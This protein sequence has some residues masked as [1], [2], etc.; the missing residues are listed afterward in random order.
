MFYKCQHGGRNCDDQLTRKGRSGNVRPQMRLT[1]FPW[2]VLLCTTPALHAQPTGATPLTRQ[3]SLNECIRMA[4]EHNLDIKIGR[5]GPRIDQLEYEASYGYYDP[6]FSGRAQQTF[7]S[8]PGRLDPAVG[9][10]PGSET[11]REDFNLSLEGLLPTGARYE[12]SGHLQRLSGERFDAETTNFVN[13]PFQYT[14]DVAIS[15]QQPL[16]KNFWIDEGRLNIQ[17]RKKDIKRSEL[18]LQFTIMN[19]VFQV[20]QFYY[21]LV[22]ARDQVKVREMALQLKR[23]FLFETKKKVEAGSL[24][25]LEEKQAESESATAQADLIRARY[26]A[27]AAENNLKGLITDQFSAIHSTTIE[28]TEKLLAV[29]QLFNVV[30]S[31]RT[32]IERRPDYLE[33]KEFLEQQNITLKFAKNQLYPALD[34]VGTYGRNG[35]GSSFGNSIDTLAD[36]RFPTWAGAVVF[37]VPLSRKAERANYKGQKVNVE[38]AVLDMK[39]LEEQIVREIDDAVKRIRSAYAAIESTREARVFAEAALDAEQKKLENGKSTNFQVLELQDRL[40]QARANEIGALTV[41]N[42]A[43]HELYFREGTTLERN[44]VTL[45]V[46]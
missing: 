36:N 13:L 39:K 4:L 22:A 31:W 46:R 26:D 30:E 8:Q 43:L 20:S 33:R 9:V 27:E 23:Q 32:G 35:L 25:P 17:L 3:M 38:T 45:D 16:L 42:K 34:V 18:L 1:L 5:S 28:P 12:L 11:W 37:S 41:Y 24:A 15:V 44:K 10:V 2:I 29:L 21:D 7:L 6:L 40:T 14:P 19:V